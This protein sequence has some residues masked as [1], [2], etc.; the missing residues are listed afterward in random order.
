[1]QRLFSN[2]VVKR[3]E[4]IIL[5]EAPLLD[6]KDKQILEVLRKFGGEVAQTIVVKYTGLPKSTIS[7]KIRKLEKMGYIKVIRKGRM[8]ILKIVKEGE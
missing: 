1:L 3:K 7:R 5:E 2:F 6:D 8:N 4:E